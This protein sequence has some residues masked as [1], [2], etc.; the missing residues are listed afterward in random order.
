MSQKKRKRMD[1]S[2]LTDCFV[3]NDVRTVKQAWQLA[4]TMKLDGDVLL[5]QT[6]GEQKSVPELLSKFNLAWH[7]AS[8]TG[9][10]HTKCDFPL[11]SFVVP[12]EC[13]QWAQEGHR[14]KTLILQG[15]PKLGKTELACALMLQVRKSFQFLNTC[16]DLREVSMEADEGL[17]LD[18]V[19]FSKL[20]VNDCKAW[21]D[22]AKTRR[23]AARNKNGILLQGTPRIFTTNSKFDEF[24]PCGLLLPHQIDAIHRRVIWVVCQDVRQLTADQAATGA[25]AALKADGSSSSRLGSSSSSDSSL[26]RLAGLAALLAD[27]TPRKR[28]KICEMLQDKTSPKAPVPVT[29]GKKQHEES[30][31]DHSAEVEDPFDHGGGLD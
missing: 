9:T 5:W 25:T 17:V 21:T 3:A 15:L 27:L 28:T 8:S 19:D 22:L 30:L 11:A 23:T 7:G 4:K 18:E 13:H 1:F 12:M 10:L 2:E 20:S 6:L 26:S 14:T 29:Q 16:D 31:L 24:W